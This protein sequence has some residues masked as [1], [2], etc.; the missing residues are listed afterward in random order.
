MR[1]TGDLSNEAGG[2]ESHDEFAFGINR[3]LVEW[4]MG[5]LQLRAER[6]TAVSLRGHVSP[7]QRL[8]GE[9]AVAR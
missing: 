7:P 3:K 5:Q 6:R 1:P 2:I 4:V 8:R 9:T